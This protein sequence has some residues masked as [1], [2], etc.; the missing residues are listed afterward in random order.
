MISRRHFSTILFCALTL[1]ACGGRDAGFQVR[2]AWARPATAG[3]NAA[4][5]FELRNGSDTDEVLLGASS[6]VARAVEIHQSKMLGADELEGMIEGGQGEHDMGGMAGE[7]VMQMAPVERLTLV[8]GEEIAFEPGGYH[9]MLVDLLEAL[10]AG[11]EF[12]VTLHFEEAGDVVVE[13][14]VGVP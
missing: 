6:E 5:Y 2:D 4:I 14:A 10:E 11:D 7:G 12:S 1:S 13:V 8:A 9:V 3:A